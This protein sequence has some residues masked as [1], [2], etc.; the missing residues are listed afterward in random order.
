MCLEGRKHI[1]NKIE[2][3]NEEPHQKGKSPQY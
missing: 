3:I 2:E 1:R